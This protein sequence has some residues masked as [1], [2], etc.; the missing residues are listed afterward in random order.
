MWPT[1]FLFIAVWHLEAAAHRLEEFLFDPGGETLISVYCLRSGWPP[2][3]RSTQDGSAHQIQRLPFSCRSSAHAS[4][5]HTPL[6]SLNRLPYVLIT[7][8]GLECHNIL[9]TVR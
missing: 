8:L 9:D 5:A 2:R 6:D 4:I 3:W 7:S 1:K